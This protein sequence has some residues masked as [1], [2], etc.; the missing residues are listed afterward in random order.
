MSLDVGADQASLCVRAVVVRSRP[1]DAVER[2]TGPRNGDRERPELSFV[3]AG[4]EVV[5]IKTQ[6]SIEVLDRLARISLPGVDDPEVVVGPRI[7]G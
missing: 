5:R 2:A 3:H 7:V 1:E 6:R 4:V